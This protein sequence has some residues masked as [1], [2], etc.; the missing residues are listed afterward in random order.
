VA[1]ALAEE[2]AERVDELVLQF[3]RGGFVLAGDVAV[4][5]AHSR[6]V[7]AYVDAELLFGDRPDQLRVCLNLRLHLDMVRHRT[8]CLR[9]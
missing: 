1:D 3:V 6:F 5:P 4:E 9:R 7:V 8:R 2:G